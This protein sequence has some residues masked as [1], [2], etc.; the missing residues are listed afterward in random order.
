LYLP[1]TKR[2]DLSRRVQHR[3]AVSYDETHHIHCHTH[4]HT[5]CDFIIDPENSVSIVFDKQ[6]YFIHTMY[7]DHAAGL[8]VMNSTLLASSADSE[9]KESQSSFGT[10]YVRVM[11]SKPWH[12][13]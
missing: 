13:L 12:H 7:R 10:G 9:M 4:C 2:V 8:A 11:T 6:N 3:L 5:H 1:D